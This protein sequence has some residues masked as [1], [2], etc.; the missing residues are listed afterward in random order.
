MQN[1]KGVKLFFVIYFAALML[2]LTF[3]GVMGYLGYEMIDAS[4]KFV[5][6][7]LLAGSAMIAGAWWLV[8]RIMRRWLKVLVGTAVT[9]LVLAVFLGLYLAL[10]FILI[11]ATPL[12]YAYIGSPSGKNTVILRQVSTDADMLAQRMQAAGRDPAQGPQNQD[13]LG[14]RYSAYPTVMNFFYNKKADLQGAV[15]IGMTSEATL[16]YEWIDDDT[17]RMS[18]L[19]PMPGDGGE[20]ILNLN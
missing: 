18:V 8:K 6:F 1:F 11:S 19:N 3:V 20:C 15:E 7:G 10:S 12:P 9:A 5:L 17:L 16:D 14:Y 4:I 2:V 13:D